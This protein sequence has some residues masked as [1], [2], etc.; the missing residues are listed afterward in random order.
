MDNLNDQKEL[1]PIRDHFRLWL[2]LI[3]LPITLLKKRLEESW[4]FRVQILIF[5]LFSI[6]LCI[7]ILFFASDKEGYIYCANCRA[8]HH[9]LPNTLFNVIF[10]NLF[11]WV[12]LGYALTCL[13]YFFIYQFEV[14]KRLSNPIPPF[15]YSLTLNNPAAEVVQEFW[16]S[17]NEKIKF[18]LGFYFINF[19]PPN[20]EYSQIIGKKIC[21]ITR[22][23]WFK[24]CI[25]INQTEYGT[26]I[27]LQAEV[28]KIFHNVKPEVY[29]KALEWMLLIFK[30]YMDSRFEKNPEGVYFDPAKFPVRL[31]EKKS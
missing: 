24:Q 4:S 26:R 19:V 10:W 30:R 7:Y 17:T 31:E 5:S 6:A 29:K 1:S 2:T 27:I 9:Y 20:G 12:L 8:G 15:E 13:I 28:D 3:S 21:G 25:T 14:K 16:N 11:I 18:N 23:W 22:G